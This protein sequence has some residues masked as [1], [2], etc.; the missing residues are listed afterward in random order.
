MNPDRTVLV[1]EDDDDIRE[2]VADVL[3]DRGYD[4]ILAAGGREALEKLR[5]APVKPRVILLDLM[6]PDMDGGEFLAEQQRDA[7]LAR[8]PVVLLTAS[9]RAAQQHNDLPVAAWLFKPVELDQL[10]STVAHYCPPVGDAAAAPR[11]GASFLE[12]RRRE[13]TL[14][15]AALVTGDYDEIRSVAESLRVSC[16]NGLEA[17]A[18]V[19]AR[20]EVA[21]LAED[22]ATAGRLVDELDTLVA[23][24]AGQSSAS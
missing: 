13:L 7:E 19:G 5:A 21:A 20:L 10:L 16:G 6:M 17:L 2:I 23:R 24:L 22:T 15:R 4:L 9:A 8:V 14:L 18:A 3:R 11:L 12:R 1:A